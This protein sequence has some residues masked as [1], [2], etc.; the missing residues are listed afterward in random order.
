MSPKHLKRYV[1][2]FVGRYNKRPSDTID[3]MGAIVQGMEGK[4]LKYADLIASN[5]RLGVGRAIKNTVA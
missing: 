1:T 3:Q 5:E 2:E 4:R